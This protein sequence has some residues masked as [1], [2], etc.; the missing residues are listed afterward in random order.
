VL[1]VED[2][3]INQK[4]LS[5]NLK[6]FNIEVVTAFDGVEGV[7][8]LSVDPNFDLVLLDLRMPKMDGTEVL[9]IVRK[10]LKLQIPVVVLTASVLKNEKAECFELGADDYMAKPFTQGQLESCLSR[11]LEKENSMKAS[12]VTVE[13]PT[14]GSIKYSYDNLIALNDKDSVNSLLEQFTMHV[15]AA[16]GE[17]NDLVQQKDWTTVAQRVHKLKSSFGIVFI[18]EVFEILQQVEISIKVD[19]DPTE[20]PSKIAKAVQLFET[21]YPSI[22]EEIRMKLGLEVSLGV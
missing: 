2:N 8:I 3:E 4:V 9:K 20:V 19:D 12:L 17:L 1:I 14:P 6:Q 15:P 16:L 21:H 10:Q 5:L 13:A 7:E 18:D 22:E 11:F